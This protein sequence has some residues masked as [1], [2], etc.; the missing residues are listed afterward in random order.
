MCSKIEAE[1][2]GQR[3]GNIWRYHDYLHERANR[4]RE[5]GNPFLGGWMISCRQVHESWHYRRSLLYLLGIAIFEVFNLR[6]IKPMII[7]VHYTELECDT[8]YTVLRVIV[9]M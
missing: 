5:Y 9:C 6:V 1:G 7:I 3:S 2:C 4:N 8:Y